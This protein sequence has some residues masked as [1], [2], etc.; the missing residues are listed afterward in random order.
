MYF[1]KPLCIY[2]NKML[3]MEMAQKNAQN[4]EK[5]AQALRRRSGRKFVPLK[6]SLDDKLK[7]LQEEYA[8][9]PYNKATN[10]ALGILRA[11]IAAVKHGIEESKRR[12][13][14]TGFFV[15]KSGDATVAL[16]GF[17]SAGKSSLINALAGT[18]SKIAEYAFTTTSLIPGMMVYNKARIQ[19]FDL[20]GIIE[21]AHIGAGGGRTVLAAAKMSDL[22]TFV[23]DATIPG[24][25]DTI[26]RE[27]R[28]LDIFINKAE[29]DIHV[30]SSDNRGFRLEVNKSGIAK[31]ALET[32]F[33]GFGKFNSTVKINQQLDEDELIAYLAGRSCY[34]R[35][36]VALNKVDIAAGYRETAE[37]ITRQYG[38]EVVPISATSGFNLDVLTRRIYGNLDIMVVYLRPKGGSE[39]AETMVLRSG[40]TVSDAARKIHSK[41]A[42][43]VQY[44]YVN[45]PSAKFRNQRVGPLHVLRDGDTVTF[46]L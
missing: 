31:K 12:K 2:V 45:G 37:R 27:L 46:R 19:I 9:T 40:S 28:K 3:W 15:K 30:Q 6:S 16:V 1:C 42:E 43:E 22:I 25:L 8:K 32:I 10:K 20:P 24:Q 34:I 41:L 18:R 26:M 23:I 14:G 44:A 39:Q 21:G 38:L 36:M 35:G 13:G 4:D 11:K 33:S 29:P 5:D 17:P 7:E